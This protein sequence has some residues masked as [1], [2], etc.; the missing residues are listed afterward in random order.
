[1]RIAVVGAGA[2]GGIYGAGFTAGGNDTT[3]VD[4]ALPL[5]EKLSAEGI[6]IDHEGERRIVQV[7]A[8][9]DVTSVGP[10][11]V[12]VFFVK[13]YH[14]TVAAEQSRPLVGDSTIV[15]SLQ[16]GWGN[17]NELA[18][19]FDQ[20]RIVVGVS[21]HS[22]T[23]LGLGSVAHTGAGPTFVGPYLGSSLDASQPVAD[24]IRSAGFEA[25]VTADV[26]TEIWKKL[27]LNAAA[28]P[29]AALTGLTAEAMGKPD[30]IVIELVDE[31]A[32]ET[33][34]VARAQGYDLDPEERVES[35]RA[36]L[37]RAG[38]GKASMLQDI[39]A[40]RRTEIDVINGA[41]VRAA[42]EHGIEVPVNRA[43]VALVKGYERAHGLSA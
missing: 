15:V 35:I 29:T 14:T 32:R 40:G 24:A 1:M 22:G 37:L 34:A 12:V 20:E 27:T 33:V 16:N 43:M 39:E 17:G 6:T 19:V 21:Y 5:V 4:V 3:L 23:V 13:C 42:A 41:V 7:H 38:P 30:E 18:R 25:V 28:L 8:T 36:I 11:D 10:V 26:R 2:M 31:L 9:N